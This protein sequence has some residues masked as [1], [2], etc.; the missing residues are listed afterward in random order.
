ML[1]GL[2]A[3]RF[4]SAARRA[5]EEEWLDRTIFVVRPAGHSKFLAMLDAP[6]QPNDRR[7]RTMQPTTPCFKA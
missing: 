3:A 4:V 5:T 7:Q 2:P 6:P 1:P